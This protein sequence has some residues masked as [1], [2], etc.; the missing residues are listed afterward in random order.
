MRQFDL[1]S[2]LVKSSE[3]EKFRFF[4]NKSMFSFCLLWNLSFI[5]NFLMWK[6]CHLQ[7]INF[8]GLLRNASEL[9]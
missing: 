8:E 5:S 7:C 1:I 6:V 2:E 9:V 3:E 4:E